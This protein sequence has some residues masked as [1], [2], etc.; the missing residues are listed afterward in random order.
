MKMTDQIKKSERKQRI[1]TLGG[2]GAKRTNVV[3]SKKQYTRKDKHK[4]SY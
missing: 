2:F 3:R 4:K 1:D